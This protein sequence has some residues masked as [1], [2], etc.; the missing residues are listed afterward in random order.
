MW[1]GKKPKLS[2]LGIF[3]SIVHVKTPGALGKLEDRRKEMVFVGYERGTK[4]YR[5]FNPNTHKVHLS[6]DAIFEEGRKWNFMERQPSEGMEL[7]ISGE[8]LGF[9]NLSMRMEEYGDNLEG[10][11][12]DMPSNEE[13]DQGEGSMSTSNEVMPRFQS[14]QALYEATDPIE[15]ECLISFEEPVKFK[16]VVCLSPKNLLF[17]TRKL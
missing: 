15:E 1:S 14:I 3:S 4:G 10:V 17:I 12:R 16:V 8:N 11:L 9:N 6:R 2:H 5:C 13:A 7:R